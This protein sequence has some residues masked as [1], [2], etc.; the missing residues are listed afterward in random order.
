MQQDNPKSGCITSSINLRPLK[1]TIIACGDL[2]QQSAENNVWVVLYISNERVNNTL[3]IVPLFETAFISVEIYS[4]EI[5][6]AELYNILM[7]FDENWC[8]FVDLTQHDS[9]FA[10]C[11]IIMGVR[12]TLFIIKSHLSDH[13]NI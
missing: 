8:G 11:G 3:S 12:K 5:H 1:V 9:V 7:C 6:S 4:L 10:K 13:K 2:M